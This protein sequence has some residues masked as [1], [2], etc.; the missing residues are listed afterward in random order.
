MSRKMFIGLIFIF[1]FLSAVTFITSMPQPKNARIDAALKPYMPFVLQK[2]LKGLTILNTKTGTI[3]KPKLNDVYKRLDQ[4]E[5]QWGKKHLRLT[6]DILS[7][8]NDQNKTIKNIQI[9]TKK[10]ASFVHRFFKI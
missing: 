8:V 6:N 1:V 3:Y 4:L 7:V 10:E 9:K 2:E 5:Q